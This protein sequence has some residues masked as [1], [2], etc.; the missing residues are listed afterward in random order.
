M[1][2]TN[3][4]TVV[5]QN[6]LPVA[7]SSLTLTHRY[8]NDP[9]QS[10]TWQSLA[11]GA[12]TPDGLSVGFN[13][14]FVRYGMDYWTLSGTLA[15]G[16]SVT[17]GGTKECELQGSDSGQTLVFQLRGDEFALNMPSG[18]CTS[19]IAFTNP[20]FSSTYNSMAGIRVKN[21][22]P[23]AVAPHLTHR[24]SSDNPVS[25]QWE[26]VAPG[27]V[28][29]SVFPVYYDT[30][31]V[32]M[33]SD[34][35][36][37]SL[38]VDVPPPD[39]DPAQAGTPW[40]NASSGKMC[41]LQTPDAGQVL[42]FRVA[43][44]AFYLSMPSGNCADSWVTPDGHNSGAFISI[45][46]GFSTPIRKVKLTH[47]YSSDTPGSHSRAMVPVGGSS[48]APILAQFNT[49]IVHAGFDYWTVEVVLEDGRAFRNAKPGKECF[50]RQ[51]DTTSILSFEVSD[52]AF[53]INLPSGSCSDGMSALPNVTFGLGI[54]P[55]KR[56]DQNAYLASHNAFAS[57][58]ESFWY[59][60]QNLSIPDQLA[61]G[62]TCLLLDIWD[63]HDDV[64][65]IH[66][67]AWLQPFGTVVSLQAGLEQIA[68][69]IGQATTPPLITI[70]FEDKVVQNRAKIATAFTNAGLLNVV[71]FA[72]RSNRGSSGQ[73]WD[74]RSQGWPTIDWLTSNGFRLVVFSSKA[75]PFPYQW[76]FM[77][78]NV[79]G[80]ASL[81]SST[82]TN[83]RSESQPL[84]ALPLCAINHFPTIETSGFKI[85]VWIDS[86]EKINTVASLTSHV[87]ACSTRWGRLPNYL[88]VDFVEVPGGQPAAAI[89]GLNAKLHGSPTPEMFMG[90]PVV[91]TG[92]VGS[93]GHGEPERVVDAAT[94]AIDG[95]PLPRRV[96]TGA[97]PGPEMLW[98]GSVALAA[99]AVGPRKRLSESLRAWRV[100][101]RQRLGRWLATVDHAVDAA[102][103]RAVLRDDPDLAGWALP[104]AVT[105]PADGSSYRTL[106]VLESEF[107]SG[108][109][110]VTAAGHRDALFVLSLLDVE[111]AES[112]LRDRTVGQVTALSHSGPL[113]ES[114]AYELAHLICYA[115]RFGRDRT[116]VERIQPARDTVLASARAA[117]DDGNLDVACEL[118]AAYVSG[119]GSTSDLESTR[120]ALTHHVIDLAV[121]DRYVAATHETAAGHELHA[122]VTQLLA[123]GIHR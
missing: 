78:E 19:S 100:A 8:S 104:F 80:D 23:V 7:L 41:M 82:W 48:A 73:T 76:A 45:K 84:N 11:P 10:K 120:A 54:D 39:N 5:V 83:Q 68:E 85:P 60:Q 32:H 93:S 37:M 96:S 86:V 94:R 79:Y 22:F 113:E 108:G 49:G 51:T 14:G 52:A 98:P 38:Q 46:N 72:D 102:Q 69:F 110:D 71:F 67:T 44:T 26:S 109:I 105:K 6:L 64:Y 3:T 33:G 9:V 31:G 89:V 13:T 16:T 92:D 17:L 81:D 4:A 63:Y 116:V 66:S 18:S 36:D 55:S 50:L 121:S 27:K 21:E 35:W 122:A 95:S 118:T 15:D 58:A 119:W 123:I 47:Q 117:M 97:V 106:E 57:F 40:K 24:Y 53:S 56:Y 29:T 20:K 88:N 91:E 90:Y 103:Y 42:T 74:V 70:I 115:T 43:P 25:F 87:T 30:G 114:D 61:H 77:S 107:G 111:G 59:A 34:H 112:R 2:Y 12:R 75:N 1:S 65:L 62:V 28:T 99:Y 101:T